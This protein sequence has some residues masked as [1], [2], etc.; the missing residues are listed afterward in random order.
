M[1]NAATS[2]LSTRWP[3]VERQQMRYAS[4]SCNPARALTRPKGSKTGSVPTCLIA[5]PAGPHT[6]RLVMASDWA[7]VAVGAI[8]G[9][10]GFLGSLLVSRTTNRAAQLKVEGDMK[11]LEER[12]K[13]D[14]EQLKEN[15]DRRNYADRMVRFA[16]FQMHKR[17]VYSDLLGAGQATSAD[18]APSAWSE[19][20]ARALIVAEPSLRNHLMQLDNPDLPL[21]DAELTNLVEAMQTDV[22]TQPKFPK[23]Q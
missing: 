16:S 19:Q 3:A 17:A 1:R 22:N 10:T 14:M 9:A 7:V 23:S 11:Q 13:A 4:H 21:R 5:A 18:G 2:G 8:T 6:G 20:L 15:S 12:S